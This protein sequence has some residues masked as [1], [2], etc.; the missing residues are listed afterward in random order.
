MTTTFLFFCKSD[1]KAETAFASSPLNGCLIL[2]FWKT[3]EGA[4]R[5]DFF[6]FTT[7]GGFSRE[8]CRGLG[9]LLAVLHFD[10]VEDL[11][12]SWQGPV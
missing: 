1:F 12:Q 6:D 2:I 7:R 10:M 8:A 11:L 3:F 5:I 4:G 9:S